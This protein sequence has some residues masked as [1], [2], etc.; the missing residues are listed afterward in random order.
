MKQQYAVYLVGPI[1]LYNS[2]GT[3]MCNLASIQITCV[4]SRLLHLLDFIDID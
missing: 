1:C 4:Q 3:V 2:T